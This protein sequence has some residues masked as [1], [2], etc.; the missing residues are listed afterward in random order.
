[1]SKAWKR[2]ERRTPCMVTNYIL[3]SQRSN[4]TSFIIQLNFQMEVTTE[5]PTLKSN[6]F[7]SI[8]DSIT[9]D[10]SDGFSC[11]SNQSDG[12]ITKGLKIFSYCVI[13][14]LSVFG[15]SLLISIIKR[16]KRMQT[17]TNYLIANM[18]VSDILIT[19]SAVPRQITEILLGPEIWLIKGDF[20]SF[21]C[22]SVSFFQDISTAVSILSLVVIAIDRYRGIVFPWRRPLIKPAKLCKV[23]IPLIW[24]VSMSLHAVYFYT[25]RV[26]TINDKSYCR[27][28]WAPKFDQK[29]SQE[30]YYVILLVLLIA[31]P[32]CVLTSLYSVIILNLK[33][34]GIKRCKSLSN[35][36]TSQRLKEDTKVVR[37]ILAILFAFMVCI[38]PINVF[39]ILMYFVWDWKLPCGMEGFVFAVYFILYLNASVNPCIYFTF[40]EKYRQGL[41]NILK[42]FIRRSKPKA[43]V[44]RQST[45]S[46]TL[47]TPRKTS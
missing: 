35:C 16:N 40:N 37:N 36:I 5:S 31:I 14:L 18:A 2:V 41:L 39:A 38:I 17:I 28:S 25:F 13:L 32:T 42:A 7:W 20:G 47:V 23:I 8:N 33:R 15:N 24:L 45:E 43:A 21:L 30:I 4:A 1:M 6:S 19:V 26:I 3:Q 34:G 11:Q 27:L 29:N 9:T 46:M 22:K 44:E 10:T 12:S